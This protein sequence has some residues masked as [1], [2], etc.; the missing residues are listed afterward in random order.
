MRMQIDEYFLSMAQLVAKRSTCARR[1]VGCVLVDIR[2]HVIA[3]GYNG[4]PSGFPHCIDNPCEGAYAKSGESLLE[5]QAIHAEMNALIQCNDAY[6]IDTVYCTT[7]PC[8][9]CVRHLLNTSAKRI[10]SL[11]EDPHPKAR[12]DWTKMGRVWDK[13]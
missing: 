7:S 5:C 9:Y 4:V 3:T 11:E 6:S 1:S 12:C 10:V 13:F 2:N 8:H